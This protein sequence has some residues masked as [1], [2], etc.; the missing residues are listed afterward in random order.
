MSA[1]ASPSH[2]W[3]TVHAVRVARHLLAPTASRAFVTADAL[4]ERLWVAIPV[5]AFVEFCR[6]VP[7]LLMISSSFTACRF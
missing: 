5:G 3:P 2:D 6:A 7:L 1:T 4:S